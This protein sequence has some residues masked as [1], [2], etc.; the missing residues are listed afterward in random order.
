MASAEEEPDQSE[1]KR[2]RDAGLISDDV[3]E[4]EVHGTE[5]EPE[6]EPEIRMEPPRTPVQALV[7]G[8]VR[9]SPLAVRDV[10]LG[11]FASEAALMLRAPDAAGASE[12]ER[13]ADH[14][15]A[16]A[17]AVEAFQLAALYAAPEEEP[18]RVVLD[19]GARALAARAGVAPA[20]D[21]EKA[22]VV[23]ERLE[24]LR[25]RL[26]LPARPAAGAPAEDVTDTEDSI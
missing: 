25:V 14:G 7:E 3:Y 15:R 12:P 17:L 16:R 20:I 2:L 22:M 10:Q 19:L 26:T 11:V 18:I 8:T 13:A 5:P 21:D 9:L 6:P 1:L 24:S 23:A 4:A